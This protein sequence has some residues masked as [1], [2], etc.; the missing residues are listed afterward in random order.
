MAATVAGDA[1]VQ[2][3]MWTFSEKHVAV[4]PAAGIHT[5]RAVSRETG[6]RASDPIP[7][8]LSD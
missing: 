3:E 2:E 1:N 5:I 6:R 4:L 8:F 7:P